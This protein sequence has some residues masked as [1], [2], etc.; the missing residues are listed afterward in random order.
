MPPFWKRCYYIQ[1]KLELEREGIL[2]ETYLTKWFMTKLFW[3]YA[4]NEAVG[5]ELGNLIKKKKKPDCSA[6]S[7]VTHDWC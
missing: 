1:D 2:R 5:M 7:F 6:L 3:E 4:V